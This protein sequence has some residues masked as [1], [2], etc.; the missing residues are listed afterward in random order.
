MPGQFSV[1]FNDKDIDQE[2]NMSGSC[3]TLSCKDLN[4]LLAL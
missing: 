4:S 3:M 2:L 1:I